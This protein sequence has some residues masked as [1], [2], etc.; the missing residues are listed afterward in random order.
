ML[1]HPADS[2]VRASADQTRARLEARLRR[3]AAPVQPAVLTLA[4]RDPRL[5]DLALSFPALLFALAVPRRDV[6]AA[7]AIAAVVAGRSLADVAQI[8]DV[9]S[10]LRRLPVN[11]LTTPLPFLPEGAAFGRRIA[12]HLPRA[13]K[14]VPLWLE[15]VSCA[16][17]WA[18]EPFAIWIARELTRG[19]KEVKT[20][21]MRLMSLWAWFSTH[22]GTIG[23]TMI[24]KRW[25]PAVR[26]KSAQEATEEWATRVT[27]WLNLGAEPLAETWLQPDCVHGYAFV[28]LRSVDEIAAEAAAMENCVNGYGHHLVHNFTRLWSVRKD[29]NRIATLSVGRYGANPFV[30]IDDLKAKRNREAPVEVWWAAQTWV[31]QHDLR[32]IEIKRHKAGR[33]PLDAAAWRALWRPYWLAKQCIPAWLP[34]APSRAALRAL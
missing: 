17:I 21:G 6:D 13:S 11:A 18:H 15:A 4:A 33:V 28:P 7:R 30:V 34:L 25:H 22:E 12:N 1:L 19:G 16:A 32:A 8:A 24:A 10:W 29:G 3:F 31:N 2:R 20:K 9:P 23:A 26:F 27:L 14:A 5:A